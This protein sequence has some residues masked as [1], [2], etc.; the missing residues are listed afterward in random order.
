MVYLRDRAEY[1][2]RHNAYQGRGKPPF[3]EPPGSYFSRNLLATFREN[4][5]GV[6]SR[7]VI[8]IYTIP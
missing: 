8:C 3:K 7:Y 4:I 6:R 5:A 1:I 2:Y